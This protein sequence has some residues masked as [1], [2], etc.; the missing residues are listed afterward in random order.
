MS[1]TRIPEDLLYTDTHEWLR[2][3]GA[4]IT[5]GITDYAQSEL[6]DIIFVE[7]PETGRHIGRGNPFGTIETVKTVEDLIAPISGEV[8]E[9]NA[10]LEEGAEQVNEDPYGAGWLLR[11][12]VEDQNELEELLSAAG[13]AELLAGE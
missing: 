1:E 8:V 5:V 4:T 7:L 12:R 13:Y 3:E 2:R 9:V 11:I 10:T 6:G